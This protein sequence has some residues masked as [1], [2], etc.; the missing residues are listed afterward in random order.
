MFLIFLLDYVVVVGKHGIKYVQQNGELE[1]WAI[2]KRQGDLCKPSVKLATV[3]SKCLVCVRLSMFFACIIIKKIKVNYW[4]TMLVKLMYGLSV[5][6][7]QVRFTYTF[8]IRAQTNTILLLAHI[9]RVA[10]DQVVESYS[11][12]EN[13]KLITLT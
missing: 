5:W 9:A 4:K 10:R 11:L 8:L 2:G 7:N 3:M 6:S 13:K 1:I 12:F